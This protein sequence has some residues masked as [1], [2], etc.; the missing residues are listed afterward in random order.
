MIY[1]IFALAL[2]R[3]EGIGPKLEKRLQ[4]RGINNL[5]ELLL[6]LP[7]EWIDDSSITPISDVVPGMLYRVQGTV[8]EARGVGRD[9]LQLHLSDDHGD[10]RVTFFHARF[11]V[12]DARLRQGQQI[13]VRGEVS[14]WQGQMQMA[15]PD[16]MPLAQ[17]QP[18][19][20][21]HYPMLAGLSNRPLQRHLAHALA[22]LTP[23]AVSPLDALIGFP[24]RQAL[25]DVHQV[26]HELNQ[27]RVQQAIQRIKLEELHVYSNLM[28]ERRQAADC[29]APL[30][31]NEQLSQKLLD[32]LPGVLTDGQ[33]KAWQ[34]IR[35]DICS[36]HRMH[37]LLQ[38]DVGSGKT[39]VAALAMLQ[40]VD[41]GHQ[42]ALMAPTEVLANQ[43][44]QTLLELFEPLGIDVALI[45]GSTRA[46]SRKKINNR[47]NNGELMVVTGTHALLS[48]DVQFQ[49]LA[50]VIVDE[51]HRFG[52]RQRWAMT[53]KNDAVHL[54]AM[55]AT[56]IP[57]TLAMALYGDLDLSIMHGLPPGR[58]PVETRILSGKGRKALAAGIQRILNQHGRV[59]WITPRIDDDEASV[60][61][62]SKDMTD[63]FPDAGVL[64]LHGRM[65]S[66]EKIK[67]LEEF[68]NG[69]CSFLV[70]TTVVE[71]GVN[72]PEARLII[73]EDAD[74]YGLAQL[75]QLRGR[76]GRS[77]EQSYCMLLPS[78][79][80][81]GQ[82][83]LRL[84]QLVE[85][86]D[87]L[88]LAEADLKYRGAGDAIGVRQS[89]DVA[90]RVLDL[91]ADA[92]LI[93]Q[94][95]AQEQSFSPL[96]EVVSSFWRPAGESVD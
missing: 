9:R 51:Q 64:P 52:V 24:L 32:S 1:H 31:T 81:S 56:P 33:Q 86:N 58:I 36:G 27:E 26:S 34:E 21:P 83:L 8:V 70:S 37:R 42:A 54:L 60:V 22:M 69:R 14:L 77:S 4:A 40:C 18:G 73:I 55:S 44:H 13:T 50:L 62:R 96:P 43:H 46:S 28:Q 89:G 39:W 67:V 59:Y 6:H 72:V 94:V 5:G 95:G 87:G 23:D 3:I 45:T 82:S 38:G 68:S 63:H 93:Q 78:P 17:F 76:V 19:I 57:R 91:V 90:F 65:K 25:L 71:V 47:L 75:H 29:I 10:L 48:R 79:E 16:W 15:H 41:A 12:K 49:S 84:Q 61:Q 74:R 85:S 80:A 7:C 92:A 2:Q 20:K 30:F 35:S 88:Q 53:E 11:L 66:A